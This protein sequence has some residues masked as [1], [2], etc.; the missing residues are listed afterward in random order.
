[1]RSGAE[2]SSEGNTSPEAAMPEDSVIIISDDE[3]EISLGLGNSVLLIE[4]AREDSF[5][6]EKLV[7]VLDEELAITFSKQASVMPHAR[8]D[9]MK[10]PFVRAEQETQLPLEENASFCSECYCYL[11]DKLSAECEYWTSFSS[12]HCNAHNKSKYWKDRRDSALA[13]VLTVFNL[14]LTEID[15]ELRDGGE[16]L[17]NFINELSMAYNK[18]LEGTLLSRDSLYQCVCQ[19]HRRKTTHP[20][21]ACSSNHAQVL[22]HSYSSIYKLVTEYLNKADQQSPKTAAVM[23]LG[24]AKELTLH[25]APPSPYTSK[26]PASNLKEATVFLMSRIV[27]ALQRLLV[28]SDY[29]KNLFE[30]FIQFFQSL[31]L[32]PHFYTFTNRLNVLSWDN[33]FLKSVLAGQN[34][35]GERTNK[36]KKEFLWEVMAVVQARVRYLV[37]GQNYRQLVRYLNAVKCPDNAGLNDLR[38]MTCFY[39]CK[40]GDFTN[41]AS[42]LLSMKGMWGGLAP[43]LVP[44][45]FDLYLKMF[46]TCSC[47]PGN[48][49][50]AHDVWIPSQG[51]PMKKGIL[52][53]TAIRILFLN[54]ALAQ[55]PI[56]WCTLIRTWC[57]DERLTPDRK[58]APLHI[59]EPDQHFQR[60]FLEKSCSILDDLRQQKHTYLPDPFPQCPFAAELILVVQAVAQFLMAST[61]PLRSILQLVFAFGTNTW[62][63][64]LLVEGISFMEVLLH[65]FIA[66][67]LKEMCDE[68]PHML[69]QLRERGSLYTAQ[70][71]SLFLTHRNKAVRSVGFHVIDVILK[72]ITTL[73]WSPLVAT[74]LNN[75]VLG[76]WVFGSSMELQTLRSKIELLTARS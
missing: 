29:P 20:C 57:T 50:V 72:N 5:V 42:P 69:E 74:Y 51:A 31:Q 55:E 44:S 64:C 73:T 75:K 27:N 54:N 58:L 21:N 15:A 37:N 40:Y 38:R 8:Y 16:Q 22:S 47:P 10:H 23:L 4:D 28:L 12:C 9:C 48:D 18:Y 56:C 68:E 14:D 67:L 25:K 65:H 34:L 1:M 71:A 60:V 49:L 6:R 13:G 24:T 52:V 59:P 33:L 11:C 53:R 35:N 36:G 76:G 41:A 39:M 2:R 7:E 63:L 70:L 26:D 46:R 43:L 17:Q 62:A 19:C 30:K 61:P 66:V 3:G 32:P 45:H